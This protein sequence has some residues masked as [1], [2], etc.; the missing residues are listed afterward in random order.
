MSPAL[1]LRDGP[2]AKDIQGNVLSG[3][4]KPHIHFLMV[5]LPAAGDRARAWLADMAGQVTYSDEVVAH[6]GLPKPRPQ[7]AWLGLGLTMRGLARLGVP[8]A[9][10]RPDHIAFV[11]GAAARAAV[12]GDFGASAPDRWRFGSA[13]HP[14]DA[15]VTIAADVKADLAARH[16]RF[17]AIAGAHGAAIDVELAGRRLA[18]GKEHFGCRDGMGQPQV[19]GFDATGV[20]PGEFVLG[21]PREHG[22][23]EQ[24]PLLRNAS[25]QVLRQLEQDVDAWQRDGVASGDSDAWGAERVGRRPDGTVVDPIPDAAHI[26]KTLPEPSP[27]VEP[28]RLRLLRRGIPYGA[29]TAAERGL[30]FNAFMASISGQFERVQRLASRSSAAAGPD[31]VIGA[32]DPADPRYRENDQ[33]EPAWPRYVTTRGTVYAVALS[34]SALKHIGG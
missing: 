1:P 25:F 22:H 10:F 30:V 8:D 6:Y 18:D 20:Q 28:S 17:D 29:P 11:D 12:L 24:A 19:K 31:A 5:R 4:N 27:T 9:S 2:D 23:R 14:V 7:V 34:L 15:V 26:R 33:A 21:W 13:A 16:D 3:F 32:P